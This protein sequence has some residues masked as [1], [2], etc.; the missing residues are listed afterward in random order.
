MGRVWLH[1]AGESH[2]PGLTAILYGLPAGIPWE[3]D[4]TDHWLRLRQRFSGRGPRAGFESEPTQVLAGIKGKV[5][6]GGPLQL[7][8]PNRDSSGGSQTPEGEAQPIRYP[9]PGHADL[10]GALKWG[11]SQADGVAELASARLTAA[12]TAAGGVC[13]QLLSLLGIEILAH[14]VRVGEAGTR[15]RAFL[16]GTRLLPLVERAEAS[17][18]LCLDAR[19]EPRMLAQIASAKETRDTVGG[20]FE[21]VVGPLPAG[22]GAPQPLE[23]RLDSR[24]GQVLMGIP[25][26]KAVAIGD[27][28]LAGR[29][30]GSRFHDAIRFA[31]GKG[32][33]RPTNRAGGLEGGMTN[34]EPL[35]VRGVLKPLPSLGTPLASASLEDGSAGPAAR[36]R[37]DVCAVPTAALAAGALVSVVLAGAILEQTGGSTLSEV[38]GRFHGND[39]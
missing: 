39:R 16:R 15:R 28:M 30:R 31:A 22:L 38:L 32:Y 24:L 33:T 2:G 37:S 11:L 9:R 35:V 14:V 23:A 10:A 1:V 3:S 27:G 7:Y 19:A 26:V 25:A 13:R 18:L 12:Y 4:R 34:G 20:E 8:L 6:N 36:V 17:R 21:V 29:A 5:T